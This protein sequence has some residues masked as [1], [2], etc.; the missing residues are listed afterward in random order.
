MGFL[1]QVAFSAMP[2]ADLFVGHVA[3]AV[4]LGF[5]QQ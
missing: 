2:H 1:A 4:G 5:C 3:G